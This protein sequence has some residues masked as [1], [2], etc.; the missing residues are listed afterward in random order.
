[1][2]VN[3]DKTRDPEFNVVAVV[4]LCITPYFCFVM[5]TSLV[6]NSSCTIPHSA[7][8]VAQDVTEDRKTFSELQECST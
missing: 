1:M 2:L 8:G 4:S 6:T 7:V 5:F 3:A